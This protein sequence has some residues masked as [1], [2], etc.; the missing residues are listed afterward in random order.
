MSDRLDFERDGIDWP[1]RE[2]SRFVTAAGLSWHVQIM[3][4]GPV[5]LLVHG[6]GAS[7]HSYGQLARILAKRFTVVVPDL[8]G[9]GFTDLPSSERLSLPGMAEDLGLLLQALNLR[10]MLAVG[11]SAGAAILVQMSLAGHSTPQALVSIN[12]ALLPFGSIAGQFFAPFAKLLALNPF[13]P[14]FVSW[15]AAN[16]DAVAQTISNTGST[17]AP[18]DIARYGR[19]FQTGNHVSAALGMLANWDLFALERDL[20]RLA[21][22]LT[23]AVGSGDRA[24]APEDAFRVR[25]LVPG[26]EV[27]LLPGLGHLAHEERPEELAEIVAGAAQAAVGVAAA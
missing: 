6:T 10:P 14:W 1:N 25:D 21:V 17:I 20:H 19:L 26:A 22:P 3:G 12:G 4:Q 24:I 2:A 9:H 5:A 16:F 7:T 23:L 27:V 13:L 15:R 11:H 18:E 8:P